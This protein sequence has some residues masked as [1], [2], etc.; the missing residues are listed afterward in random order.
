MELNS[1]LDPERTDVKIFDV[2]YHIATLCAE[3]YA[4][5][6]R[7]DDATDEETNQRL[8]QAKVL[9]IS[10]ESLVKTAETLEMGASS[11]WKA[12]PSV[13]SSPGHGE[14][15]A[16]SPFTR[17]SSMSILV[18]ED[19]WMAF[20]WTFNAAAQI[21]LRE[22]L[23]FMIQYIVAHEQNDVEDS[24]NEDRIDWEKA[25]IEALSSSILRSLPPLLGFNDDLASPEEVQG[26]TQQGHAVGRC[27]VLFA[28]DVIT[29]VEHTGQHQ[30]SV[31]REVLAWVYAVHSSL[32]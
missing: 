14:S 17:F 31:A 4:M 3:G 13:V 12:R 6:A 26:Y 10:M 21:M 18:Y 23:I 25:A 30:K 8:D 11:S 22:A 19:L 28:L 2:A 27:L 5:L 20:L 9:R 32:I 29:R 16:M 15:S 7:A 24:S 1:Q